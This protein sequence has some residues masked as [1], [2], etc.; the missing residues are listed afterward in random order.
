MSVVARHAVP[1]VIVQSLSP[2]ECSP[3]PEIMQAWFDA[4]HNVIAALVGQHDIYMCDYPTQ[5]IVV[6]L[7]SSVEIRM[8]IA[9][10]PEHTTMASEELQR[11]AAR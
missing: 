8:P 3:R 1:E 9:V 4:E 5:S 6:S 10:F 7:G 11:H 2:R